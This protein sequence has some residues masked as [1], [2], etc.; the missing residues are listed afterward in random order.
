MIEEPREPDYDRLVS[1]DYTLDELKENINIL[2]NLGLI[3]VGG[4]TPDGNWLY[5]TTE[6]ANSMPIQEVTMLLM[7]EL[8]RQDDQ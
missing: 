3:E 1:D 5:Q 2:I 6:K 7:D 4:I 8:E